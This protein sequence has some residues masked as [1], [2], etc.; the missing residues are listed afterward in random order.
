S[1]SQVDI[2]KAAEYSCEDSDQTLDVH[3][4]LWPRLQA[5]EKLSFIY[6]LEMDSSEAL[7][8]VERNGVLIDAPTLAT[9]SH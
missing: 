5:D 3:N 1:F 9:Q 4:T 2:A 6:Q 7:Y 8:R